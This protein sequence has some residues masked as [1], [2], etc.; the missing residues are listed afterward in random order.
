MRSSDWLW[1][2]S[3]VRVCV[4]VVGAGGCWVGYGLGW[5]DA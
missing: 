5:I 3:R 4:R 1:W 2:P